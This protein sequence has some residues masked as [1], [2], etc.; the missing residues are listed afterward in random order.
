MSERASPE[1]PSS[2]LFQ[3][4]SG[5]ADDASLTRHEEELRPGTTS[6]QAGSIN[7]KKR[8]QSYPGEAVIT[9]ASEQVDAT[10]RAPANE[11]DSGEV[12]T[13][14]DGSVSIPV[15]EE[16]LVVTKRLVVRERLI[17]RKSTT[18]DEHRI[19]TELRK[20]RVEVEADPGVEAA[21][22]EE[23]PSV[24]RPEPHEGPGAKGVER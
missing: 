4:P 21:V 20:E 18:V 13:L 3:D 2:G 16:E 24:A 8:V 11:G 14:P 1:E 19:E 9:R 6:K 7:V 12:E 17:V 5:Q 10:E 23:E 22:E 15:F